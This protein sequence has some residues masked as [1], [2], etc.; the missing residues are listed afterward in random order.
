MW[1]PVDGSEIRR[2]PVHIVVYIPWLTGFFTS[3]FELSSKIPELKLGFENEDEVN[4]V[5]S[6]DDR[7]KGVGLV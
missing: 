3:I 7:Q 2:S 4:P 5:G 1:F 6:E